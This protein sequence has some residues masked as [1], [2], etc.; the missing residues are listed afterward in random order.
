M[1]VDVPESCKHSGEIGNQHKRSKAWF[2]CIKKLNVSGFTK[3]FLLSCYINCLTN[4]ADFSVL[5]MGCQNSAYFPI[6]Y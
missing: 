4:E 1:S 5:L 3:R 2:P 6:F